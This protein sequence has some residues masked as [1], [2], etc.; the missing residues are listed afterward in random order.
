MPASNSGFGGDPCGGVPKRLSVMATCGTPTWCA[1]APEN[2]T[3]TVSCPPGAVITDVRFASFG[4]PVGAC[5]GFDHGDCHAD[6][7]AAVAAAA[8]LGQPSCSVPATAT[9]F[10]GDS[11]T[12]DDAAAAPKSL[13]LEVRCGAPSMQSSIASAGGQA[14]LRCPLQG[15]T[16][17]SIDFAAY[18]DPTGAFP[19]FA[20][21]ACNASTAR[22]VVED[23]CVGASGCTFDVSDDVFGA[24]CESVT[25]EA[26]MACGL[27]DPCPGTAN[28]LRLAATCG[29]PE[30]VCATADE[31]AD[32]VLTCDAGYVISAINFASYGTPSGTCPAFAVGDCA[33][34]TSTAV[35][36]DACVGAASCAVTA[37]NDAFGGD[38][39]E[40][41]AKQLFVSATCA[42]AEAPRTVC[43]AAEEGG[44]ATVTCPADLVIDSVNFASFGTP[45]GS[46]GAYDTSCCHAPSSAAVV[47]AA[48]LGLN[49]CSVN[50]SVDAFGG[51]DP[52]PDAAKR[53]AAAVTCV[54]PIVY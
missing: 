14:A 49:T 31:G 43:G 10:G 25:A 20:Y 39:C 44:V 11:C 1:T 41:T 19:S 27:P 35:L 9:T 6:A 45:T 46:C 22:S 29:A 8:C 34:S 33:S 32:A 53:L 38:P 17:T 42:L 36:A 4:T 21:G 47:R 30:L 3:A 15:S 54:A 37:S 12:D 48:C 26:A 5:G 2:A 40:F 51:D 7:S 23:T 18:G 50:V 52:C 28:V 13:A 16:L 24:P